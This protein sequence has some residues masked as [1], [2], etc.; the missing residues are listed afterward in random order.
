M[1]KQQLH[2][3]RDRGVYEEDSSDNENNEES[4]VHDEFDIWICKKKN[5]GEVEGRRCK[6]CIQSFTNK[7]PTNLKNHLRSK[8]PMIFKNV[9]RRDDESKQA[10]YESKGGTK[11]KC[12]FKTPAA[13][14][15]LKIL[16]LFNS[17]AV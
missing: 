4:S 17:I 13:K 8:Y 2:H 16:E 10:A 1:A 9:M 12:N 15:L 7:N 3:I 11:S 6:H 5:G 14:A